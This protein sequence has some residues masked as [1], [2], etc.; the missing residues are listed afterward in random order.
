M[1]LSERI[2]NLQQAHLRSNPR[3]APL[4]AAILDRLP[5][6]ILDIYDPIS[7]FLGV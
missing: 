1:S 3:A 2:G 6:K 7:D 5:L 4:K